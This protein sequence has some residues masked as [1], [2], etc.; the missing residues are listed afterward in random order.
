MRNAWRPEAAVERP[1]PEGPITRVEPD[2]RHAGSVRI[3]AGRA[4]Y[5]TVPEPVAAAERL[6]PGRPIDAALH[7]RLSAAADAD[8]AHR[9]L[10]RSLERRAAAR[11]DLERRLLRRGHPAAAVDAALERAA[12][13][14]FLD[15]AAFARHYVATRAQRGR[16]PARLL[17]DLLARGVARGTA[18][19][20][21]SE[22]WPDGPDGAAV[23]A[24]ARKRAG[25]LGPLARPVLRRRLL[26]YMA[27][28]GYTG[29]EASAAVAEVL[30]EAA[31]PASALP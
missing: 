29:S 16:G 13:A 3:Y 15:D 19:A 8:A 18:Q 26:A 23:L 6:A 27:R 20:A 12:Q 21:I 4:L 22:Q 31:S 9:V 25:Q 5:C 24:L 28:R 30:R 11:R 14:G 17:H 2:P 7:D 10:V 1:L